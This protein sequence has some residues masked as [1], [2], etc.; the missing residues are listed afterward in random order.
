L[1]DGA[2]ELA[3][4]VVGAGITATTS[5]TITQTAP[6]TAPLG[7]PIPFRNSTE[8]DA[9]G[10]FIA[11]TKARLLDTG[12]EYIYASGWKPNTGGL[13]LIKSYSFSAA[14][15]LT[16]DD[17]SDAF[18]GYLLKIRAEFSAA[19]YL[20]AVLRAGGS[21]L[22]GANYDRQ[23]LQGSASAAASA[24][25]TGQT[26]AN[27]ITFAARDRISVAAEITG[28]REAIPTMIEASGSA[29]GGGLILGRY[30]GVYTPTTIVDGVKFSPN[31]GTMTGTLD[32]YG[33][34]R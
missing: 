24:G 29:H 16:V 1:P 23:I 2:I 10:T 18:P 14:S 25:A 34:V 7:S 21:D 13:L 12:K 20:N 3:R 31:T 6:F 19:A 27:F 17:F 26:S 15:S 33:Y 22:T 32:V 8:R 5:A 30:T 28:A 11:G 4:A 9:A